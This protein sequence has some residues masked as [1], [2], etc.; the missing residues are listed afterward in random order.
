M[1]S[2]TAIVVSSLKMVKRELQNEKFESSPAG[3]FRAIETRN[4]LAVNDRLPYAPG[5]E[6]DN[7]GRSGHG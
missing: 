4:A 5:S 1:L 7:S 3:F 6:R 2:K